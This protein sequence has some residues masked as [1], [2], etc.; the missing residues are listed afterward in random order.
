MEY[1]GHEWL[2]DVLP[3]GSITEH[4]GNGAVVYQLPSQFTLAMKRQVRPEHVADSG[5]GTLC[6]GRGGAALKTIRCKHASHQQQ[7][8]KQDQDQQQT[9]QQDHDGV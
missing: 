4:G 9:Q 8:Q 1:K 6:Y 2:A 5:W 3:D 7:R